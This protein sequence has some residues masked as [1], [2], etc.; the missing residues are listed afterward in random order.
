MTAPL[1]AL[2][3][4]YLPTAEGG[5]PVIPV[6]VHPAGAALAIIPAVIAAHESVTRIAPSWAEA[7]GL[8][9]GACLSVQLV[10]GSRGRAR[11]WGPDVLVVPEIDV[12]LDEFAPEPVI[13]GMDEQ[14]WWLHHGIVLGHDVLQHFVVLLD[15]RHGRLAISA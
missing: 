9:P 15:G 4:A 1:A 10:D 2:T 11:P 7:I 3:F 6:R 12:V 13:D 14:E 5:K 8:S